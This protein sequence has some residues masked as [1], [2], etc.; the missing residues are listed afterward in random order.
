MCTA[1]AESPVPQRLHVTFRHLAL[2]SIIGTAVALSGCGGSDDL[3][4]P[5]GGG[6]LD[7]VGSYDLRSV[8]GDNLP[9][10]ILQTPDGIIEVVSSNLLIRADGNYVVDFVI[11]V[12]P[13]GGPSETISDVGT[14]TW[15]LS[16]SRISLISDTGGCTDTGTVSSNRITFEEECD[17]GFRLVYEK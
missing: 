8:N 13:T 12:T 5:G 1:A 11:R 14:G 7:V 15:V 3:A 17:S 6:A 4:G 9:A 2:T 10:T 16:G